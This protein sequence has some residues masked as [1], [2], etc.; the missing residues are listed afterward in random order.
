M[1]IGRYKR[2]QLEY[3]FTNHATLCQEVSATASG[4][5]DDHIFD[6]CTPKRVNGVLQRPPET[7]CGWVDTIKAMSIYEDGFTLRLQCDLPPVEAHVRVV[8]SCTNATVRAEAL[9]CMDGGRTRTHHFTRS[10]RPAWRRAHCLLPGLLTHICKVAVKVAME[11][12]DVRTATTPQQWGRLLN[13]VKE[14]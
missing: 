8:R 1:K 13:V 6:A 7:T 5:E 11:V 2:R 9:S 3:C 12:C 4:C 10:Y 14:E